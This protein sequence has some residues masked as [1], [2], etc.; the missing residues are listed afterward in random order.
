MEGSEIVSLR[1]ARYISHI[2]KF[3][4]FSADFF[5]RLIYRSNSFSAVEV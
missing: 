2:E 1:L 3:I 4:P 5:N